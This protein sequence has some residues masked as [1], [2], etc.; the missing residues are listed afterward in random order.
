MAKG[1]KT[2][3]RTAGTPNKATR[4][5]REFALALLN[6]PLFVRRLQLSLDNGT[7]SDRLVQLLFHY[8]AGKPAQTV[9]LKGSLTLEQVVAGVKE[10]DEEAETNI[11][12]FLDPDDVETDDDVNDSLL[13][14]LGV[15]PSVRKKRVR[16]PARRPGR[17]R[18]RT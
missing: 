3:G 12:G 4:A 6:R 5:I 11:G 17:A 8:A 13:D 7:C 14:S 10:G 18:E 16:A 2:G 15:D 9:N 1:R